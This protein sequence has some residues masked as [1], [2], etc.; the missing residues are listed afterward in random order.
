MDSVFRQLHAHVFGISA[1]FSVVKS[2]TLKINKRLKL[3]KGISG[4][5][6][7]DASQSIT[8]KKVIHHFNKKANAIEDKTIPQGKLG[9]ER[10][11][12]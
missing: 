10:G 7:V 8:T 4:S 5:D 11:R 12:L 3:G 2:T 6:E 9:L 1:H